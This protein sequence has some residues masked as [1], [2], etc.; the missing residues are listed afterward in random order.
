MKELVYDPDP[1][2]VR[3]PLFERHS[4]SEVGHSCKYE[5]WCNGRRQTVYETD[6]FHYAPVAVEDDINGIDVEIDVKTPFHTVMIR[7]SNHQKMCIRDRLKALQDK[8]VK[9]IFQTIP[10]DVP[11]SLE[12]ILK[13]YNN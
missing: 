10:E 9:I 7:P 12:A 3:E 11:Q 5:L 1:K 6:S 2:P 13:K 8:G 4:M